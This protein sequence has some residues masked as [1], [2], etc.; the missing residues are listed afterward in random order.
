MGWKGETHLSALY[1]GKPAPTAKKLWASGLLG[2]SPQSPPPFS[3]A[4]SFTE[5]LSFKRTKSLIWFQMV[6]RLESPGVQLKDVPESTE[7]A[8]R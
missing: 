8:H 2:N 4:H 6:K 5:A 1:W 7:T 3:W